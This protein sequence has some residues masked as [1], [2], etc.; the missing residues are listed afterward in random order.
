MAEV[1]R[2]AAAGTNPGPDTYAKLELVSARAPLQPEPFLLKAAIASRNGELD[3]AAELLQAARWR[4]PRSVAARYLLADVRIRQGNVASGLA[5][6]AVLAQIVPGSSVQLVPALSS[7]AQQ[8]G[9]LKNLSEIIRINPR[10]KR[11]L[12]IAL[13]ADTSNADMILALSKSGP[14]NDSGSKAWQ[15]RLLKGFIDKG[16][17]GRAY[18]IWR[19]FSDVPE[20][21]SPLLFNGEFRPLAAPPPFNWSFT[22]TSAGFAEPADGT[23]RVLYFGRTDAAL[24]GQLL[25]LSPGRY[26]LKTAVRGQIPEGVLEWTLAC[27]PRGDVILRGDLGANAQTFAVPQANCPAQRLVLHGR[28]QDVPSDVDV[29]LGPVVIEP[30]R[31]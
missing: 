2:A 9:A 5:E 29:R 22:S 23:L 20:S 6:M 28:A 31:Q 19:Q 18:S 12:L 8:P 13:A 24:A 21:G 3:R 30:V 15:E 4:S 25:L 26:A 1:G 17:Y 10:L 14:Q 27:Q 16:D 7:Y 11:P